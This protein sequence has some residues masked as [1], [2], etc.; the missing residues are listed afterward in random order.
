MRLP[1]LEYVSAHFRV[2]YKLH[3]LLYLILLIRTTK[4]LNNK[5][6]TLS[7]NTIILDFV[8]LSTIVE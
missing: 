5:L 1:N 2:N 3:S 8:K 6:K 4:Y 7:L